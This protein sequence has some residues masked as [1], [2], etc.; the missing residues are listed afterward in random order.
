MTKLIKNLNYSQA[1]VSV[2]V[3]HDPFWELMKSMTSDRCLLKRLS[4]KRINDNTT[5]I[6]VSF[7]S[8]IVLSPFESGCVQ[9]LS[10]FDVTR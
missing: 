6:L 2:L 1:S 7:S 5:V 10:L 8:G 3:K 4:Q 9:W